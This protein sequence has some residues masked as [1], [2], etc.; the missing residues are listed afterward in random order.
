MH[1]ANECKFDAIGRRKGR[2]G[3]VRDGRWI[4]SVSLNSHA[5]SLAVT[6]HPNDIHLGASGEDSNP[7]PGRYWVDGGAGDWGQV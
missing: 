5:P 4:H 2:V 1:E 3:L 7:F 6:N